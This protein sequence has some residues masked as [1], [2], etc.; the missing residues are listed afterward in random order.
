MDLNSLVQTL[1]QQA[2]ATQTLSFNTDFLSQAQI[3]ALGSA[4]A[5]STGTI[6]TINGITSSDIPDPVNGTINIAAGTVDVLNQTQLPAQVVF[7]I[8]ASATVQFTLCITLPTAWQFKNSF[9]NLTVFPFNELSAT[10]SCFIYA[11]QQQ[12][13]YLPWSQTS[14]HATDSVSLTSGLNYAGWLTLSVLQG[15]LTLLESILNT[16]LSY[17]FTGPVTINSAY[18][19]PVLTLT[20]PLV[21]QMF[22]ITSGLSI[23][24]LSLVIAIAAPVD[25]IQDITLELVASTD[26]LGFGVELAANDPALGFFAAPLPNHTFGIEQILALPGGDDFTQ[27]IPS[28]LSNAFSLCA[29][30]DFF[31]SLTP[32]ASIGCIR[33][34]IGSNPGFTW[35]LIPSVLVLENV[36]LN[37]FNIPSGNSTSVDFS[38]S[39]KIL[40]DIF[41]GDFEFAITVVQS[42]TGWD[43]STISGQ[44]V[45]SV[46]LYNLVKG[47]VGNASLLPDVL[48]D[49]SFGN[50]GVIANQVS[51]GYSY[52]LFGR[53]D[54]AFPLMDTQLTSSLQ[55]VAQYSPTGYSVDLQGALL[56]GQQNFSL[57][58]YLGSTTP[59]GQPATNQMV[60]TA[61]WKVTGEDYLTFSD[62]AD[63]FG[64]P[65]DTLPPIPDSM[66]LDLKQADLSYDFV[67][68]ELLIGLQ[69][70]NYGNTVFIALKNAKNQGNWQ[71]F[72]GLEID[73]TISLQGLPVIGGILPAEDAVEI[74]GLKIVLASYLFDDAMATSINTWIQKSG[75]DYPQIPDDNKQGM[76]AGLGFSMN[77]KIGD[78]TI[79]I[80]VGTGESAPNPTSTSLQS[81]AQPTTTTNSNISSVQSDLSWFKLHE[82]FGP[83]T[84]DEIGLN[85]HDGY[86]SFGISGGF[87][88]GS[89]SFSLQQLSVT[90]PMPPASDFTLSDLSFD[91]AGLA[92][93][94]QTSGVSVGGA[95]LRAAGPEN[96]TN[97]YGEVVVQ[98]G[99]WGFKV[100]GGYTPAST[101]TP[102]SFFL[103]TNIQVPLGG[104]P[105]LFLTGLAGGF[106]INRSLILPTM[107]TLPT[108]LLLPNNA[109]KAAAT[110]SATVQNILPQ[111]QSV[112]VDEPG[113]YW[114]AAGVSFTSF[115]IIEAFALITVSVGV[116]FQLG[117]IGTG[118]LRLPNHV[119]TPFAYV[120]LDI[121]ATLTPSTGLFAIQGQ[122]SPQSYIYGGFAKL[123]GGFAFF[124]WFS[125]EHQ[126]DFVVTLGGYHPAFTRP[127]WYPVVPR[128]GIS[129][130]LGPFQVGGQCYFALTP[131]MIM[132]GATMSATWN[133][134]PIKAWF[135]IGVDF[136]F[137]WAPLSYQADAYIM[138]GCSVNLGLF[139]LNVHVGADLFIWGDPFGGRADVDL[140]V[141]SFTIQFGSPAASPPP[142]GWSQF[143]SNFLPQDTNPVAPQQNVMA[144]R[145][146]HQALRGAPVCA[147]S[148]TDTTTTTNIIKASV[149]EGL[150][151]SDVSGYS[152]IID[153][154]DF[155]ILTNSTIP[156]NNGQ[157]FV[158]SE[159][160]SNYVALS[161]TT[162]DYNV[163]PVDVTSAP[164]LVLATDEKTYSDTQVWNPTLH[165]G[166]M[167][168]SNV[169]SFHSVSLLKADNNGEYNDPITTVSC[170]PVLLDSNAALWNS[171]NPNPSPNDQS[172]MP[173]TLVGFQI[174]PIPRIPDSTSAVLLNDLLFA[175]GNNTNFTYQAAAIDTSYT[176]T[177]TLDEN[178]NLVITVTGN[179][180]KT[181]T[182]QNYILSTLGDSWVTS[183]RG[184]I[185]NDLAANGFSTYT[186]AEIDIAAL[187]T[188]KALVDWPMVE[189]LGAGVIAA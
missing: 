115:E 46:T 188:Q 113:Q 151:Q 76:A 164:Y 131:A 182:N 96:T 161:N 26:D 59:S 73:K 77:F 179:A 149:T 186:S 87:L 42:S 134:G 111:L 102:V 170:Q 39:A 143:K 44:Y 80:Q 50:F 94:F 178:E 14:E 165:I 7:C 52:T 45:G 88:M 168:Q 185:L 128:L 10:C 6:L 92:L 15:A 139:T 135:N 104:P 121:L 49:I 117:L 68:N 144:S 107:A 180:A 169:Q 43:V 109:P 61:Q 159:N 95:F 70:V 41:T 51:G 156:A 112:F 5:L 4:F 125:G 56:V 103:Y 97:Y 64:F 118:A 93:S 3:D 18:P 69:S 177:P 23:G 79:P 142:V 72:F 136:L 100:I 86:A 122:L 62:V 20:T 158:A 12:T 22:T 19:Y 105:F 160:A 32:N 75:K 129:F 124:I 90:M 98:A 147:A 78:T 145:K 55:V 176:V 28:V 162:K 35:E 89:F 119:A 81:T 65:P 175:L 132:A 106:G 108:Y 17:K 152:W 187:A 174:T 60:L 120:E 66:D 27:Y 101:N 82:T 11:T 183:Q 172:M 184:T 8:D 57:E 150:V 155:T 157:W 34:G 48:N 53:C 173:S 40:P 130:S 116:D 181:F 2:S 154:D 141:V 58:L 25:L 63:A 99:V 31:I 84:I 1:R 9:S 126:G 189:L 133:S 47:L 37:I 138:M 137:A 71:F 13:S 148:D 146:M 33:L 140:D 85:Y 21:D 163:E 24:N 74:N 123:T 127:A 167:K 54:A 110:P 166:P 83:V 153:S 29:L 114:V 38:A 16:D 91:L 67:K 171:N 36:R 30:Q